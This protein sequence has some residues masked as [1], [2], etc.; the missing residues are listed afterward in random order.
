MT[1]EEITA[2]VAELLKSKAADL[3]KGR[4]TLAVGLIKEAQKTLRWANALEVKKEVE[5]QME[6]VL[7]PKDERDDPKL[8]KAKV[9]RNS[10]VS[11]CRSS[12]CSAS[13]LNFWQTFPFF[14]G[15]R[16]KT[17]KPTQTLLP[18]Q[19]HRHRKKRHR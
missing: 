13:S 15:D 18:L 17:P 7:G 1:P 19:Q 4:Y 9:G 2:G 10:Y 5:A 12:A 8:L 14:F 16:K 11:K 6:K 3:D